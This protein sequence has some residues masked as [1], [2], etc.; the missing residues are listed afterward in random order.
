MTSSNSRNRRNFLMH[1]AFLTTGFLGLNSFQSP[2]TPAFSKG[3]DLFVIGPMDGFSPQIGTL[4]SMLNYNRQTVINTVQSL[5]MEELDYLHD[6]NSNTIGALILHLGAVDKYCQINTFACRQEFNEKVNSTIADT[7]DITK[8]VFFISLD[9][10]I[11]NTLCGTN[12]AALY[13]SF[14][15][16]FIWN[17]LDR[18]NPNLTSPFPNCPLVSVMKA[19]SFMP[20]ELEKC[21]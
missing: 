19:L 13:F 5:S 1:S 15:V 2:D 6:A 21:N 17:T 9:F 3:D 18:L 10:E 12:G 20:V 16:F 4:V 7:S 8:M 14:L 11:K